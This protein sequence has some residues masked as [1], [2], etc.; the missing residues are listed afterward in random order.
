MSTSLLTASSPHRAY[1]PNL[2]ARLLHITSG[3]LW[4]PWYFG[5]NWLGWR[6]NGDPDSP[7]AG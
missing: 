2:A 7:R 5:M 3:A 4:G 1:R 6:L